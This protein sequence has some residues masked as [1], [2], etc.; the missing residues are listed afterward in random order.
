[1]NTLNKYR[2]QLDT[3]GR[4]HICPNCG[5]KRFVRFRD[6]VTG[7]YLPES[8][9]RCDREINCS[10]FRKPNHSESWQQET[11]F[12]AI[13]PVMPSFIP[14]DLFKSSLRGYSQNNFISWLKGLFDE[15]TVNALIER[16]QIGTSTH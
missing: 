12:H 13:T 8:F 2:Y 5:K 10:Y 14:N 16:Y 11:T 15:A 6:N 4:K 7:D 9:G 1:M 3:S